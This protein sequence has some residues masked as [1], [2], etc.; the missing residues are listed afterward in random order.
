V[1]IV[2]QPI[3]TVHTPYQSP[4]GM[5]VQASRSDKAPGTVVLD[6]AYVEGLA[7]LEGFSHVILV[8]HL[9][10]ARPY[11]LRVTPY[12]DD[13]PRGL[14]A[15]RAPARPNPVGISVVA[16]ERIDGPTLYVRGID[17][18]DGTPLLDIKPWVGEFDE[19]AQVRFG[20][21][22]AARARRR[23]SDGRFC[24]PGDEP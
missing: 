20:W 23:A 5:P 10:L 2:Y 14:F 8:C 3:G 4:D 19:P 15:T 1:A 21:L 24:A 17:L 7:D 6:E 12:L 22:E 16:L 11:R 13:V 18:I 9:H